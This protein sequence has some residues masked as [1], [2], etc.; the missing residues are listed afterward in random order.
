MTN[1]VRELARIEPVRTLKILEEQLVETLTLKE[2]V[3]FEQQRDELNSYWR[4]AIENHT[5]NI[6]TRSM[7][8]LLV[9]GIRDVL[10]QI[11][12]RS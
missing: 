8:D 7:E 3:S 10:E 9:E 1:Q 6:D 11:G 12:P 2:G 5:Q 4:A